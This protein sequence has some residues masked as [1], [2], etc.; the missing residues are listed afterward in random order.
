MSTNKTTTNKQNKKVLGDAL[1]DVD[2]S[3][4]DEFATKRRASIMG[5]ADG[6]ATALPFVFSQGDIDTALQTESLDMF[7]NIDFD[8]DSTASSSAS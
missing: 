3:V 5:R 4:L 2:L 1:Y 7:A 8:F 6:G